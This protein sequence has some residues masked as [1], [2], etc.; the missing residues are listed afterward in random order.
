[1]NISSDIHFQMRYCSQKNS[2]KVKSLS[3]VLILRNYN[4]ILLRYGTY[5][6]VYARFCR[7]LHSMPHRQRKQVQVNKRQ[8][9]D[10]PGYRRRGGLPFR[11]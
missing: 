7:I 3:A 4:I 6:P 8:N 2:R 9:Q 11:W 10:Q 5:S 1:M